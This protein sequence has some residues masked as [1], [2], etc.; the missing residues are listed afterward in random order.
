MLAEYQALTAEAAWKG[1][2]RDAV[3]AL[4]SNPLVL[5]LTKAEAIYDEMAAAHRDFLP[6]RLVA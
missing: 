4:A 6:E 1:T 3:R 2:R 5:S